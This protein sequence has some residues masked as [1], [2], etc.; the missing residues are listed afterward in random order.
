MQKSFLSKFLEHPQKIG[1]AIP[2]SS[3]LTRKMT[4]K[5]DW[6]QAKVIVELGAGTGVITKVISHKRKADCSVIVI[7][8]DKDLYLSLQRKYPLFSHFEN[9]EELKKI[10]Q[11]AGKPK[12]DYIISS[13]PFTMWSIEMTESILQ[14]IKESIADSG[15][16]ILFQYS[17]Y[18]YPTLTK[19]FSS[20]E[21][22]FTLLNFPPAIVYRCKK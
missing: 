6:N 16:F 9:A 19:H 22:S 13:L 8:Q 5:I 21:T 1:S 11:D 17:P 10:L 12:A 3:F 20:I 15:E 7:E 14:D 4:E 18:L 2:S